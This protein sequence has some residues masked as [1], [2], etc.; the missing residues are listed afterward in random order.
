MELRDGEHRLAIADLTS[1][2]QPFVYVMFRCSSSP[3]L[4]VALTL[5]AFQSWHAPGPRVDFE[6]EGSLGHFAKTT[7]EYNHLSSI[8]ELD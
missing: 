2:T 6:G 8:F 5:N 4:I 7:H 1:F 3:V